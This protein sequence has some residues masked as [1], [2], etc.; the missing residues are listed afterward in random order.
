MFT[1]NLF[2]V[3]REYGTICIIK[4]V[5]KERI[6][7]MKKILLILSLTVLLACSVSAADCGQT[8]DHSYYGTAETLHSLGILQG[9][10]DGFA[11]DAIPDRLQACVMVVRMRGEENAAI[12]AYEAG[13]TECPFSDVGE[14]VA[15]AKPYLAWLYEKEIMLGVGDGKFGREDC[16]A[17]MYVT[18][19]LRALGYVDDVQNGEIADFAFTDALPFATALGIWDETLAADVFDRGVMSAV[20]YQTLAA[21]KKG[22]EFSLLESL[23]LS[24]AVM[25]EDA[26][27]LLDTV[28]AHR[29]ASAMLT[30]L[31]AESVLPTKTAVTA[32]TE[33]NTVSSAGGSVFSDTRV[34]DCETVCDGIGASVIGT[35]TEN[36]ANAGS[37]GIWYK[38]GTLY[39]VTESGTKIYDGCVLEDA[40]LYDF[41][42]FSL[43]APYAVDGICASR[44][45]DGGLHLKLG[46]SDWMLPRFA[47]ACGLTTD[48]E[49]GTWV[50]SPSLT[51]DAYYTYDGTLVTVRFSGT[52]LCTSVSETGVTVTEEYTVHSDMTL[53]DTGDH[54]GVVYPEF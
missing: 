8:R 5:R 6:T 11:L 13:E 21:N 23:V 31:Q 19:M 27:P 14:D 32:H 28:Y 26:K 12:A 39:T 40:L 7:I 1:I 24:G 16:T 20:T 4:I 30:A 3:R 53:T 42:T 17:Q 46:V 29:E 45:E 48:R 51:V 15:W 37:I 44:T 49:D 22:G 10:G 34:L 54:I 9:G 36:G 2:T 52:L 38:D 18:F 25:A 47:R 50:Y 41:R 43:P 35:Y 33:W